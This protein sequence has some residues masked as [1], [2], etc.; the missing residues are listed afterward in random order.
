MG[1]ATGFTRDSTEMTVPDEGKR[2]TMATKSYIHS[3]PKVCGLRDAER[4]FRKGTRFVVTFV[5]LLLFLV[6]FCIPVSRAEMSG[7]VPGWTA[8]QNKTLAQAETDT[9]TGFTLDRTE[10]DFG[11]VVRGDTVTTVFW[12]TADG[13]PVVLLSGS[14][15][16]GCTWAE[17]AK[18]P[19]RPG[20][21]ARGKVIF[22][23]KDK[24]N[25]HKAVRLLLNAGGREYSVLLIVQGTVR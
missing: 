4:R 9:R 12:V 24:G 10:H 7:S 22:V 6:G 17:F 23:A 15:N 19:L 20:D 21:T 2:L 5:V 8:A 16:C 25:F 3:G 11:Q 14:S 1:A 13:A 18:R